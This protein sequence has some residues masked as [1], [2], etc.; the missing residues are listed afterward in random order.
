MEKK[1][2]I[3]GVKEIILKYDDAAVTIEGAPERVRPCC[4][5]KKKGKSLLQPVAGSN[6]LMAI[7]GKCGAEVLIDVAHIEDHLD[8]TV[9]MMRTISSEIRACHVGYGHIP[10]H[11]IH[12]LEILETEVLPHVKSL[13]DSSPGRHKHKR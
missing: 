11:I 12:A 4:H 1:L 2:D 5:I 10:E 7:C 3:K 6:P 8:D 13:M 9:N